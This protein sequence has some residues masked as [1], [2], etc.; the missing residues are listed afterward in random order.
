MIFFFVTRYNYFEY[1]RKRMI[2]TGSRVMI[3][4]I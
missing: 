2:F 3:V 1:K 4:N